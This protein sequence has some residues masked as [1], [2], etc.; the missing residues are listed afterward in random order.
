MR[1]SAEFGFKFLECRSKH[2]DI[3]KS[4]LELS[5]MKGER[6]LGN[7]LAAINRMARLW[8]QQNRVMSLQGIISPDQK[9]I[10]RGEDKATALAKH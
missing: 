3:S 5:N 4:E 8:K 2:V 7:Q 10:M 1:S 6:R 9:T